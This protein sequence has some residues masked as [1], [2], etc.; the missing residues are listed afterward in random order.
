MAGTRKEPPGSRGLPRRTTVR[1]RPEGDTPSDGGARE[2]SATA[3]C[4]SGAVS[5]SASTV[6]AAG[7]DA[8]ATPG[9]CAGAGAGASAGLTRFL[10]RRRDQRANMP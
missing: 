7:T 2:A 6:D 4:L 3:P 1:G 10:R 8:S 5:A 9:A